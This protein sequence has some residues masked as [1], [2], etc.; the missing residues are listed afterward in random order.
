MANV[1][2]SNGLKKYPK[3]RFP[4][5]DE[6]Y[7]K[8]QIGDIY[9][10]RGQRGAGD[11]ELLSVTMNDGVMPRSEIEGKDN[12]SEDKSNYKV[13]RKD[14]MVYNSMRMWQGANGVSNYD[15]IVS[16][17]YTVLMPI[18]EIDNR[19]FA[20]LFKTSNLINEFRKKS[21]GLTSDTWNVNNG[22]S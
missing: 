5:F 7:R 17:A 14:D 12:S 3:L 20:A 19:Y 6:P 21:Q 15:G 4:E 1:S 22:R 11:M 18:E 13:V 8:C 16:P 10:E 9:V 2:S